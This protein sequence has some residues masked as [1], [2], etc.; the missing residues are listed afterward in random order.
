[1]K[2]TTQTYKDLFE[3]GAVQEYRITIDGITYENDDIK[4]TIEL[5]Q[6]LF[7]KDTF[8]VGSF[9]VD[10][11][12]VRLVAFSENIPRRASVEFEYRYVS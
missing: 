4:G 1:M 9:T 2:T 3:S 10:T 12:K 8:T 11:L 6:K 7:D 5:S